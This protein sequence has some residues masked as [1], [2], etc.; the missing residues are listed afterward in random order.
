[1]FSDCIPANNCYLRISSQCHSGLTPTVH[2][3]KVKNSIIWVPYQP[4]TKDNYKSFM[5]RQRIQFLPHPP[6]LPKELRRTGRHILHRQGFGG[7]RLVRHSLSWLGHSF[8][9]GGR[10]RRIAVVR[11]QQPVARKEI[12]HCAGDFSRALPTPN[13]QL[14]IPNFRLTADFQKII[15]KPRKTV[16]EK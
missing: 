7:L 8:G 13:S 12:P 2:N 14:P 16:G 9:D 4:V 10:T 5:K 6:S 11:S 1:M 15:L 3:P